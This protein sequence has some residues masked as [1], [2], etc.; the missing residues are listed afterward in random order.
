MK[1]W[2]VER[3]KGGVQIEE[4]EVN[5]FGPGRVEWVDDKRRGRLGSLVYDDEPVQGLHHRWFNTRSEALEYAEQH[6]MMEVE[7]TRNENE[8]AERALR[9]FI[10]KYHPVKTGEDG[11]VSIDG[12][13]Q[14]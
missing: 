5:A 14:F 1:R 4:R 6:L 8:K 3:F 9:T 13:G 11:N 2:R 7:R 10:E 12:Q